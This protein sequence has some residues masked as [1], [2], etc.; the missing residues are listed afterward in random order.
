MDENDVRGDE[1]MPGAVEFHPGRLWTDATGRPIEAHTGG[2]LY[3]R[4]RYYWVGADWDGP[5]WFRGFNLYSSTNLSEWTYLRCVLQ[6]SPALPTHHEIARPK[7]LYNR[8]TDSYVM[9]FKRK[10]R[11]SPFN[12]VRPGIAVA[13]SLE[14]SFEY[15]RDF[16]PGLPEYNAADFCLWQDDDGTA[17]YIASC[18]QRRG[19]PRARRIVIFRLTADYRGVEPEP[20]YVGPPDN[21]EAPAVFR[22]DRTYFLVTSGTTGWTPNQSA[23]RTASSLAGPWSPLQLLGDATTYDSQPDFILSITGSQNTTYLYCG[24][25]HVGH[26]LVES[27]YV[28]LPLSVAERSLTL[29]FQPTWRLSL[30][31]GQ[32]MPA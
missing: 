28:W 31:T 13:D 26:A 6:P 8:P 16:Y 23:Y 17:Y 10:D 22:H 29:D 7:I 1:M 19:G 11:Q 27:T 2:M 14:G 4:G 30:E 15:L 20:I 18:P 12:D 21:R 32:W 24:G 9:W 5:E 25:R 3:E